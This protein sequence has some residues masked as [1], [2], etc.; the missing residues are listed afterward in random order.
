MAFKAA[1]SFQARKYMKSLNKDDARMI[2]AISMSCDKI[3]IHPDRN[4]IS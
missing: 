2:R 4:V 1:I 3:H